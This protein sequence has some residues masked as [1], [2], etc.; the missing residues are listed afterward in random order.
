MN[1]VNFDKWKAQSK[2]DFGFTPLKDF[3]LPENMGKRDTSVEDPF[4]M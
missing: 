4:E 3:I 2:S 1:C